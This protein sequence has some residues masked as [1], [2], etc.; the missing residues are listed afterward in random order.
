MKLITLLTALLMIGWV[1]AARADRWDSK[2]WEKLGEREVNGRA[3]HDRIDVGFHDGKYSKI[4]L[5]VEKSDLELLDVVITF[6][7]NETFHPSVRQVFKEGSRTRVIDLPGKDR[8]I[9]TIDLKY[10]N[11]RGGGK[12]KVEVWGW[13]TQNGP[14][15][16]TSAPAGGA[17]WESRGWTLLGERVVNGH[18]REDHDTIQVGRHEGKFKKLTIVVEDSD[19][20][21]TDFSVK[22]G[23]GQPWHPNVRQIFKEGQRTR[24]ID[25]PGNDRV[26]KR[27]DFAYRNLPGGGKA[28]VAVWAQ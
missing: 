28:K 25:F 1:G 20:E 8:W 26:I 17:H 16:T 11:I 18:G 4:T 3:D 10:R 7:N 6:G 24:V 14:G 21:M 9:K 2:G 13:K 12:A 5:Y 27:I 15:T 23:A 22:F 19:L